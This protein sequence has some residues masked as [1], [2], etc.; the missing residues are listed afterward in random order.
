MWSDSHN[1]SEPSQL[2]QASEV[3]YELFGVVKESLSQGDF[4]PFLEQ[5]LQEKENYN[6]PCCV[7]S[8]AWPSMGCSLFVQ[9]PQEYFS[10]PRSH[11]EA[12]EQSSQESSPTYLSK[13]PV[14]NHQAN[15]RVRWTIKLLLLSLTLKDLPS[16]KHDSLVY[17]RCSKRNLCN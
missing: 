17:P 13:S 16:L 6:S 2:S 15:V 8:E 3:T 7:R 4:D 12:D 14:D 9:G 11:V 10:P 1:N 5:N